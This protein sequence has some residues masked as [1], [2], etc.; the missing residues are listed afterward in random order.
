MHC[1]SS[2]LALWES[3]GK[4][5]HIHS[6][7]PEICGCIE[8]FQ[9]Q[10]EVPQVSRPILWK[11]CTHDTHLAKDMPIEHDGLATEVLTARRGPTDRT[12]LASGIFP[13]EYRPLQT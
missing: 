2:S 3:I 6:A 1:V 10:A 12:V 13:T 9:L 11:L 8:I 5:Q 4:T 7:R